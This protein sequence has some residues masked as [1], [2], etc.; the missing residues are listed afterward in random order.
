MFHL[1][2]RYADE[3]VSHA[4]AEAPNECCGILAGVEGRITKLYRARNTENSPLRYNLDPRELLRIVKE[5]EAKGWELL[6]IYHSHTHTEAYPSATDIELALWPEA[7]YLIVSLKN[8]EEATIRAFRI[9]AG[10]VEEMA[11]SG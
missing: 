10:Q 6:G 11:I 8:P 4:K 7:L 5:I 1:G 2:K 9:A 3:L